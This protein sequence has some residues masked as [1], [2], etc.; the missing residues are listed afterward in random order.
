VSD[1]RLELTR[2]KLEELALQ[3]ILRTE[4]PCASALE[5]AA[6]LVGYP[7]D[8][9]R[10]QLVENML[11]ELE[12]VFLVGGQTRMPAIRRHVAQFFRRKPNTEL[13]PEQVVA[14]GA[15]VLGGILGGQAPE[16]PELNDVVPLSLGVEELGGVMHGLIP[17]N[18]PVPAEGVKVFSTTASNQARVRV[19]VFQGERP[20]ARENTLLFTSVLSGIEPAPKGV[21]QIQVKLAVDEGGL[22]HVEAEDLVT[23]SKIEDVVIT[24]TVGMTPEEIEAAVQRAQELAPTDAVHVQAILQK[25]AEDELHLLEALL[26]EKAALLPPPLRIEAESLLQAAPPAEW[27]ARYDELRRLVQQI[28]ALEG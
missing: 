5:G 2:S 3:V 7:G 9:T 16:I 20:L 18:A 19:S 24:E 15:G 17:R 14:L 1:W 11:G 4:A 10:E 26:A 25:L 8:A 28:Y 27:Q 22:L 6:R 21:P 23:G 13:P 12:E